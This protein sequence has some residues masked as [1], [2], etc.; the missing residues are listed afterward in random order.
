MALPNSD[1]TTMP[2]SS[3]RMPNRAGA[4]E[5]HVDKDKMIDGVMARD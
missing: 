2:N 1:N 3:A 5:N 4:L